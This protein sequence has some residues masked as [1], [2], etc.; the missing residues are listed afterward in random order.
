[1][2]EPIYKRSDILTAPLDLWMLPESVR[3]LAREYEELEARLDEAEDAVRVAES[4]VAEAP[5][6]DR[7][8]T[9]AAFREG[10]QPPGGQH[11]KEAAEHLH[12]AEIHLTTINNLV[13]AT[14][15]QLITKL[16]ANRRALAS[17]ASAATLDAVTEH[18]AALAE[19]K[20]RLTATAAKLSQAYA[21]VE[22]VRSL[23]AN[24][25]DW[26]GGKPLNVVQVETGQAELQNR[27]VREMVRALR[28]PAEPEQVTVRTPKGEEW[29]VPQDRVPMLVEQGCTVVPLYSN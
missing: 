25:S 15:R 12:K 7:Q 14:A 24:T 3:G 1:M 17:I 27:S 9:L 21:A 18:E 20:A 4:A 16:R 29:T 6:L 11:Q 2:T 10:Q 28:S 8:A 22:L 13:T 26:I 19:S 5:E 23:D